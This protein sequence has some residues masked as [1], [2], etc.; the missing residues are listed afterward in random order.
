MKGRI[1]LLVMVA[2]FCIGTVYSSDEERAPCDMT[3]RFMGSFHSLKMDEE[4]C[5]TKMNYGSI[6]YDYRHQKLRVDYMKL[7]SKRGQPSPS[8]PEGHEEYINGTLWYDFGNGVGYHYKRAD[9]SCKTFKI[10]S[11]MMEPSIPDTADFV[12]LT[13]IG[14]QGI[15]TWRISNDTEEKTVLGMDE[16]ERK[17]K[18]DWAGYLSFTDDS[19]L[20][21]SL[22]AVDTANE[23]V[24]YTMQ[25]WDVV[26]HVLPFFFEMPDMC[27]NAPVDPLLIIES[28]HVGPFG[29]EIIFDV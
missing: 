15:E 6:Q 7:L 18:K 22:M 21:V 17:D 13:M 27:K 14:G 24:K 29:P 2:A 19:C 9:A 20:P 4:Y 16:N 10:S 3:D 8:L 1:P 28:K 5:L 25:L 12:G 26:P 11:E 23:K